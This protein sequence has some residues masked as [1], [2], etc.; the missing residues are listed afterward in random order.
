MAAKARGPARTRAAAAKA[1]RGVEQGRSLD[2]LLEPLSS[3]LAV[4][5]R[6]M[7]GELAYGT[8]RWYFRLRPLAES[9]LAR[10]LRSQDRVLFTLILV[11]LYQ[12]LYTR[13]PPHAALAETVEAARLLGKPQG[14]GLINAVLRRFQREG[15]GLLRAVD[16][17]GPARYA[18]PPWLYGALTRAWPDVAPAVLDAGNQRPPMTLR[19]NLARTSVAEYAA[20]LAAMGITAR[21]VTGVATALVLDSPMPVERL[22]GFDQGLASVQDAA[23]QMAAPLL[24]AGPGSRVLDAC[25]APGGKTAH[26][27]EATPDLASLTALDVD[28]DRLSRVAEN[29]ARLGLRAELSAADASEAEG[30][31]ARSRYDRI[32]LDAPCSATGV[33]R[34][35]PD[36]KLLRRAGDVAA[37]VERQRRLMAALWP[38]LRPGGILLYCTC[39]VLPDENAMQVDAFS[40]MLPDALVHDLTLPFGR[41]CGRGWQILPGDAGCDG[42]F[43]ARLEKAAA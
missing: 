21:P 31:W 27:A 1:V 2:S 17:D 8:C 39:S 33:I 20:Q 23:A 15:E 32:L 5:Q 16:A 29:L 14:A 9:M 34:R 42:F 12:L 25:A 26:I 13:V 36:I 38:L 19:V 11:G 18:Y 35:H 6:P 43:Y 4:D 10:P 24:G 7:L 41:P 3:G 28:A 37:L 22:P 30:D 40:E